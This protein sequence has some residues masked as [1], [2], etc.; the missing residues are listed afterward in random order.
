[1]KSIFQSKRILNLMFVSLG[2]LLV[3][4]AM[5]ITVEA[6]NVIYQPKT[7]YELLAYLQG[8]VDTLQSEVNR[9]NINSHYSTRVESSTAIVSV[10]TEV[11][12]SAEFD[13]KGHN[14]I[15]AWFE[16][17]EGSTLDKSTSKSRINTRGKE[18][19]KHTHKLTNLK[20]GQLYTYRAVF[21]SSTG[22]KYY[23]MI[24]SFQIGGVTSAG[25]GSNISGSTVSGNRA[26]I[27]TDS[28]VYKLGDDIKVSWTVDKSRVKR[29]NWIGMYKV[30]S[31]N[32]EYI[33]WQYISDTSNT[34]FFKAQNVGTFEFRLFF[35]SSYSEEVTSRRITVQ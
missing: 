31:N 3:F 12:F 1:M 33:S 19:V 34:A 29:D 6:N 7:N 30:G 2:A 16:Y 26:S 24:K 5:P 10:K 22:V 21:E 13:S 23:G 9:K 32:R 20:T 8:V 25:S 15:L 4:S 18:T 28:T 14:Y 11:E 27:S 35:S 17:G